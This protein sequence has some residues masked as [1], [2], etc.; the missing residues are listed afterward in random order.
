MPTATAVLEDAAEGRLPTWA[1]AGSGRRAHMAR[2]AGLL[3]EWAAALDSDPDDRIRARA[4]AWLHDA[5][6]DAD[7]ESLRRTVEEGLRDLPGKLIHGPAVA[8]RLR[9]EGVEDEGLLHAITYHTLGHPDFDTVG[10]LLYIADFLEPGRSFRPLWRAVLRS[11]MPHAAD[12]VIR[13]VAAA[14]VRHL[15]ERGMTIR[16]ETLAFWNAITHP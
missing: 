12:E 16:P 11:R 2:V 5:L 14:R 7:P 13:D 6:R 15:L 4:A 1:R 3:D 10:R 8:A 9:A